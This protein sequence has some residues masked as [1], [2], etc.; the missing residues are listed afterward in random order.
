[1]AGA[2]RGRGAAQ[3]RAATPRPQKAAERGD[4]IE[5]TGKVVEVLPNAFFRVRLDND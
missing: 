2:Y 1:M 4:A 5:M 3:Q